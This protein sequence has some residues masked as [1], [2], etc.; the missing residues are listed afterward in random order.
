MCKYVCR[1]AWINLKKTLCLEKREVKHKG[2]SI[3]E[4]HLYEMQD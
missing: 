4:F 1:T 3:L 2:E